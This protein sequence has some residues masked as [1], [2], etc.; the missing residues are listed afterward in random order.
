MP[1]AFSFHVHS[2]KCII[3]SW[4]CLQN[5]SIHASQQSKQPNAPI[6]CIMLMLFPNSKQTGTIAMLVHAS[7]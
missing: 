4:D 1:I 5:L 2:V 6:S 7:R 3:L